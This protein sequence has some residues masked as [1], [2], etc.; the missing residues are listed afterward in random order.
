MNWYETAFRKDY[1]D[2]YYNRDDKAAKGEAEFAARALGLSEH[3]RVLDIACGGGRHARAL[4]D[5]GHDV[6]GIDLSAELLAGVDGIACVRGDMRALPFAAS[7]DAATSFFTSFGYFDEDGN[8]A[9]LATAADALRPRGAYLLDFLN[10]TLVT[11]RLVPESEEERGGTVYKVD[12]RIENGRVLKH[13]RIES[14]DGAPAVEYTESVRLYLHNDLV[15]MMI[16]AGL[17]PVASY[18]DF[19]GRDFTTDAPRCIV[20]GKKA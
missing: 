6:V 14:G 4:R 9:V 19:D 10:A 2:L 17:S 11:S 18:G 7:F 8:R 15:T 20:V 13:V 16:E 12:R 3:A 1:L 5:L